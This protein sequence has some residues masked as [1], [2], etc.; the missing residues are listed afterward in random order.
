MGGDGWYCAIRVSSIIR[1]D[2]P[3]SGYF[4]VTGGNEMKQRSVCL[5]D[6]LGT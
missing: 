5:E 3:F 6:V 1:Y 4:S 2:W